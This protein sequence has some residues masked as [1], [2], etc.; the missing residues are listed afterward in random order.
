MNSY[1]APLQDIRFAL[2]DVIGAEAL[3]ARLGIENAQRDI[4]DA[5]LE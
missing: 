5:V 4:M 1:K 2:F 3:Y